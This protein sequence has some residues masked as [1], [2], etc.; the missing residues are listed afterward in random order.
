MLAKK[1]QKMPRGPVIYAKII[2]KDYERRC[3]KIMK[4][5]I[6]DNRGFT[7]FFRKTIRTP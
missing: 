5:K 3:V 7:N 1:W 4:R 6:T 2:S